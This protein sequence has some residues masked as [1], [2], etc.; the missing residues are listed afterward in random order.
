MVTGEHLSLRIY[1]LIR[2]IVTLKQSTQ[3]GSQLSR[4]FEQGEYLPYGRT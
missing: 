4:K 3:K 2:I 1:N